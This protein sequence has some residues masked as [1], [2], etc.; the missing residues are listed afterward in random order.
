VSKETTTRAA[1][2]GGTTTPNALSQMLH[3]E[4]GRHGLTIEGLQ[5]D[6]TKEQAIEFLERFL[7]K[8]DGTRA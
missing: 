2:T 4:L 1:D 8:L 3:S 6:L 5:D 7:E